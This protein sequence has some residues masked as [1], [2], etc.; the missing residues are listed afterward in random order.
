MKKPK[1]II[2][3]WRPHPCSL[4]MYVEHQD[5][6]L[7]CK[8]RDE[9]GGDLY[10]RHGFRMAS[11]LNPVLGREFFFVRGDSKQYDIEVVTYMYGSEEQCSAM[12]AFIKEAVAHI[13]GQDDKQDGEVMVIQ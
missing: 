10:V 1:L 7:R 4:A 3:L 12:I 8:T 11:R 5:E 9:E 2:K 6:S 13:N